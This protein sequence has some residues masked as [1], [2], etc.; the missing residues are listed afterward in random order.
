MKFKFKK[1]N[2]H[3][4]N[5][6]LRLEIKNDNFISEYKDG[7]MEVNIYIFKYLNN[8]QKTNSMSVNA[9]VFNIVSM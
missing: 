5:R 6:N 7:K 4:Q 2:T 8:K 3:T 1:K 9:Q